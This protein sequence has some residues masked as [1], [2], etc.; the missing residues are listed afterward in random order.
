MKIREK[1]NC[2]TMKNTEQIK[3]AGELVEVNNHKIHVF[4]TGDPDK[5]KLVF[6][7]GS[8]TVAPAYDFK[9]LYEKLK[10]D[11][12][13]IVTEKFGYG[14][15]DIWDAPCDID[16]LVNTQRE[17][18]EKLGEK[19][20]FVLLP[21]SMGGIEAIRWIQMHPEEI[22]AL[23]GLDMT[24]HI[25]YAEWTE[26]DVKSRIKTMCTLKK[27]KLYMLSTIPH[28]DTLSENDIRQIKLLRKRNAFNDCFF[29]E[30]EHVRENALFVGEHGPVKCPALLFCSNGKQTFRNWIQD[31]EKLAKE[32]DAGLIRYDCGHY[33]HYYKSDEMSAEIKTFLK[34]IDP[35]V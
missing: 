14:Y 31:Q 7:S 1:E 30:A 32:L 13:I 11:F 24:S 10:D 34:Q 29:R 12:R 27:L 26:Q 15:S 16:S 23:I 3:A 28:N 33:L 22:S 21:H 6:M 8:S 18:L 9:I 5:P 20:P 2:L 35:A 25:S 19:G 17:A 4:R